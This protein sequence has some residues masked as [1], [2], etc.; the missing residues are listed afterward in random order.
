M[1]QVVV[2]TVRWRHR[3]PNTQNLFYHA[4][5][6][7]IQPVADH[8]LLFNLFLEPQNLNGDFFTFYYI[9][10]NKCSYG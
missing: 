3:Y 6:N 1:S 9:I 10:E 7:T 5:S 2:G 8:A 4:S